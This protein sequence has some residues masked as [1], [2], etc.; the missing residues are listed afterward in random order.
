MFQKHFVLLTSTNCFTNFLVKAKLNQNRKKTRKD[1]QKGK[2]STEL[3]EKLV[4]D[5]SNSTPQ[6][7][8]P[9]SPNYKHTCSYICNLE[10]RRNNGKIVVRFPDMSNKSL[11]IP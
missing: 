5:S 2:G 9:P 1:A 10:L 7:P 3:S 8:K 6:V 4:Y 11:F